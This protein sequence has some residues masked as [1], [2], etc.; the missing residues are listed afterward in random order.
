[1]KVA[2]VYD[3]INKMGGAERV[4]LCLH[5]LF[6]EAPLYTAVYDAEKA[7]WAKVFEVIPSFMQK[8]PLAKNHHELFPWLTPL[9]FES[10]D[11]SSYDVVISITSAEAKG[12]ITKP[13]TLH[14]CYCLTPTRYLWSHVKEYTLPF[15]LQFLRSKLRIWDQV[16]S[17][18]P[19]YYLAISK[20]VATRIKKYYRREA[21]VIYPGVDLKKW[22]MVKGKWQIGKY[23]LIVSRLVPY[24]KIDLAVK[25]FN[26]LKWPLVVVGTGSEE[27]KLKKLAKKNIRFLGH[28]TDEEIL[29]YYQNCQALIFPGEEDYGLTVLEAQACGRP[30]IAYQAGGA[31]ETIKKGQTGEFF[32]PQTEKALEEAL[33]KFNRKKYA[34][35]ACRRQAEKFQ[36]K[37]FEKKFKSAIIKLWHEYRN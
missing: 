12:I 34:K 30:V 11:F 10:L 24:K 22:Q 37:A 26:K 16:A 31:L 6:P 25:V 32:F 28:L 4:L 1:M 17:S 33:R 9:A 19:D 21:K 20:N 27:N 29:S 15:W 2:L 36:K 18:R 5:Q 7:S 23:Y 14:I 8:I 3:R 35:S 13:E